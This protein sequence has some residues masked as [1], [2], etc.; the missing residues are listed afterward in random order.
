MRFR[1]GARLDPSQVQDRRG[2]GGGTLAAGGGGLGVVGIVVYLLFALL[3]GGGT[4]TYG[5]L[6]GVTQAQQPPAQSLGDECR[7]GADANTRQDCRV[8][9]DVNSVQKY[10]SGWFRAH[11]KT[12]TQADTVFFTGATSTGCGQASTDVGPFYCPVDRKVYIDL[13]FYQELHDRF[14]AKGGPFAE[15]YV[16]AHEYGHHAQDLLGDLR[17]GSS[18]GAQSRSVRTELQADCYAGVWARNAVATGY[19]VDLTDADIADGLDA[20]AAVGD[21]RIQSET[22]GQVDPETWTHGSSAERQK[23]FSRGYQRGEPTGCDTF[24]GAL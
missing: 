18:Q 15:A 20:A 5:S 17:A 9:A 6:D 11:G 10:W 3:G 2:L 16:I 19:I 8:L 7:T 22:Q 13:G 24:S 23:W 21:D 1:P 4:G 12:Y 14:G